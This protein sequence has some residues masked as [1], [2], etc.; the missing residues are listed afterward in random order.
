MKIGKDG[1]NVVRFRDT[2]WVTLGPDQKEMITESIIA[3]CL[4]NALLDSDCLRSR[5]V[6]DANVCITCFEV[7]DAVESIALDPRYLEGVSATNNAR[8]DI[9][10]GELCTS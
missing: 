8:F 5:A 3:G 1:M 2:S 10:I 6:G 7:L 9:G 4:G